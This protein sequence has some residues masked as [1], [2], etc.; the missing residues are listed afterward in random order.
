[1]ILELNKKTKRNNKKGTPFMVCL[2]CIVNKYIKF[3]MII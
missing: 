1:M 3:M 2:S